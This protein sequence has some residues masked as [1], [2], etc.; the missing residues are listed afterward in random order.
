MLQVTAMGQTRQSPT[1]FARQPLLRLLAINLA[2]GIA[3]AMIAVGG[4]ILLNPELRRLI[5]EDHSPATAIVMLLFGFIV[6]LASCV[7]GAAIMRI[8]SDR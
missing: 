7:M 5:I 6:T 4:L 1:M 3:V 8:G 2:S